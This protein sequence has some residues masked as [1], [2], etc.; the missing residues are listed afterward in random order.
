MCG[1][2]KNR[3]APAPRAVAPRAVMRTLPSARSRGLPAAAPVPVVPV[4]SLPT[5]D[6]SIWGPPLWKVLHTASV[7]ATSDAQKGAFA[8][9]LDALRSGIPCPECSGHFG[10]WHSAHPVRITAVNT[11]RHI[12]KMFRVS[13]IQTTTVS[14]VP[15]VAWVLDLHNDVNVRRGVG[16]WT[17]DQVAA[18]YGSLAGVRAVAGSLVGVIGPE[19]SSAIAKL[20]D[21][22]GA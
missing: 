16:V 20:L 14:W 4:P 3:S 21:A 15:L 22:I 2:N 12:S 9:V 8:A 7:F 17:A 19:A 1:C 18:A 6:T 11:R 13:M 10:Q 5:V